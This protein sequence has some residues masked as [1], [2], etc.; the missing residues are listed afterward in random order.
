MEVIHGLRKYKSAQELAPT[1]SLDLVWVYGPSIEGFEQAIRD[2]MHV[3]ELDQLDE[4]PPV[5]TTVDEIKLDYAQVGPAYG[6]TVGEIEAAL[7]EGD[8]E[9]D[10]D[11]LHVAGETLAGDEFEVVE[12]RSYDG[13]GEMIET[14][15]FVI[16]VRDQ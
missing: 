13:D 4:T 9:L 3:A 7:D 16:I 12:E 11:E 5:E 6:N 1:D 8:Y 10:G 14:E 2:V 15:H